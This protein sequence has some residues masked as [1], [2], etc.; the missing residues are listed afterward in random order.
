M[1][2]VG[3][4]ASILQRITD[5]YDGHAGDYL[6]TWALEGSHGRFGGRLGAI[7]PANAL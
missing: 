7:L 4:K 6:G 1:I 3:D 2:Q 5:G